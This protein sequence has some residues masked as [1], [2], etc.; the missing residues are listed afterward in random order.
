MITKTLKLIQTF[1]AQIARKSWQSLSQRYRKE[2]KIA[3]RDEF[4]YKPKWPYFLDLNFLNEHF[5][6]SSTDMRK[7]SNSSAN[8][9]GKSS[10][11]NF[12]KFTF[13]QLPY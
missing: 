6:K 9:G 13:L 5:N 10:N 2:M 8:S 1:S 3:L 4:L 7:K 12:L 11:K